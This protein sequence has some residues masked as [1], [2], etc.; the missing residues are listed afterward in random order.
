MKKLVTA[1][2]ACALAGL[3]NA[4]VES[5]NI[6]GYQKIDLPTGYKMATWTFVPVGSDGT[7]IRLGDIVP[8]NFDG[9]NGDMI[10]FFN[11]NGAGSVST[12]ATYY[13]D[14]GWCNYLDE[15]EMLDDMTIPLGTGMFVASSQANVSFTV[16]GEVVLD[17]FQLNVASG[18]TVVGNSSPVA[19]TL[20]DITPVNFDGN[21]GDM[22][23]IFAASGAVSATVT[24]YEDYG[25]CNYL[26][27]TEMKDDMV[28]NPGDAIFFTCT[29]SGASFTFPN[30]L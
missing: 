25:W 30:V 15:T 19:I 28:L 14:Y 2:A 4:Q 7:A 9:N 10:Q 27:E 6:V 5:V 20:G 18:Y 12:T 24:Y 22:G 3:V 29:L 21:N 16:A 23:Q 8:T 1:F 26:D 13:E 17:S 11:L